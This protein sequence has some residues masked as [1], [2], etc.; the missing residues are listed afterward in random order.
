MKGERQRGRK[1]KTD[2]VKERCRRRE[3]SVA[4]SSKALAQTKFIVSLEAP[5]IWETLVMLGEK[6]SEEGTSRSATEKLN[7]ALQ[8]SSIPVSHST[9]TQTQHLHLD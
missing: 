3:L 1:E 5:I 9:D 6:L 2:G 7:L 4:G 8:P